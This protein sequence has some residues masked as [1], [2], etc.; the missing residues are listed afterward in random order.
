MVEAKGTV[1]ENLEILHCIGLSLMDIQKNES[2]IAAATY[3]WNDA[4]NCFMFVRGPMTITLM[5]IYML[6]CL[7]IT[8]SANPVGIQ[9]KTSHWLNTSRDL[10]G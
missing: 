7:D 1:W 8:S 10:G 9:S 6:T 3:F 5:D 2:L 4:M